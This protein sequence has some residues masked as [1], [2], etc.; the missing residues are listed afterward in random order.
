MLNGHGGVESR[1]LGY[2]EGAARVDGVEVADVAEPTLQPC[3]RES[4]DV[5]A[6]AN[7]YRRL[8]VLNSCVFG[9]NPGVRTTPVERTGS[10]AGPAGPANAAAAGASVWTGG[11]TIIGQASRPRQATGL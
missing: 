1:L 7:G 10:R 11:G 8:C 4:G 9:A 2:D 5:P 3:G 6:A